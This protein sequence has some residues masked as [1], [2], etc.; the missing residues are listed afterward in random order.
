M[1]IDKIF[2]TEPQPQ[3]HHLPLLTPILLTASHFQVVTIY[4]PW[5]QGKVN[6]MT[7]AHQNSSKNGNECYW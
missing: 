3:P 4:I 1:N 5:K 7:L 6:Y 2:A